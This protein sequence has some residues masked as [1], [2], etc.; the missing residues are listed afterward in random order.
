MWPKVTL[1]HSVRSR[2][3]KRL[4]VYIESVKIS[5]TEFVPRRGG[6]GKQSLHCVLPSIQI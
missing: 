1:L 3:A 6:I 5:L 2:Q 4:Y